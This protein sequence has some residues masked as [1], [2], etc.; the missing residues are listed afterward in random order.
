[1][2]YTQLACEIVSLSIK[3][4]F[5]HINCIPQHHTCS[6]ERCAAVL[7]SP[8]GVQGFRLV[9]EEIMDTCSS[10]TYDSMFW[11]AEK[12]TSAAWD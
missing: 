5:G 11:L 6:C 12:P 8:A 9:S 1:M 2:F 7:P 4:W 3:I 10:Y